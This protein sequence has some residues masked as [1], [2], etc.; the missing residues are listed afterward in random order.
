MEGLLSLKRSDPEKFMELVTMLLEDYLGNIIIFN[1]EQEILFMSN[2]VCNDLHCSKD[3][4][5]GRHKRLLVLEGIT[6]RSISDTVLKSRKKEYISAKAPRSGHVMFAEGTPIFDEDGEIQYIISRSQSEN[7]LHHMMSAIYAERAQLENR[8][9]N[10]LTFI[11]EQ[12]FKEQSAVVVRSP[13]MRQIYSDAADIAKTDCSAMLYGE[14]GVGKEVIARFIHRNSERSAKPFIPVNCAAIPKELIEAEFFGYE[15]GAFTGA[16]KEGKSGLFEL[17][18]GGTLFLDEI[19]ELPIELQP[20]LLRVLD[21]G[22]VQRIGGIKLIKTDVRVIS[23]TNRNLAKMMKQNLFRED[24]YYRLNVIPLNIPALRERREEIPE[25]ANSFLQEYNR[26]YG[27]NKQFAI[28]TIEALI[29]YSWPGNVRELRNVV[30]RM[31]TI[32]KTNIMYLENILDDD[33]AMA[34]VSFS[35]ATA[36]V[37]NYNDTT[38]QEALLEFEK[39]YIKAKIETC[40]GNVTEAARKLGIH[41]SS[42]Y[43]KLSV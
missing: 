22:E 43:R 1:R 26:K 13:N 8:Y 15:K 27:T 30:E 32:S 41:R 7:Q 34:E 12:R 25:M 9:K 11:E 5:I 28:K 38:L 3:D 23:A 37:Y 17:A 33:K 20:K 6:E 18:D 21:S 2:S 35:P 31:A 14:P 42:I 29:Q 4:L 39:A 40:G 24:L 10:I 36:T 16:N 19:G